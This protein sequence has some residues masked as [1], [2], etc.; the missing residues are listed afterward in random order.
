MPRG[1]VGPLC[2]TAVPGGRTRGAA[3]VGGL[4]WSARVRARGPPDRGLAWPPR[5]GPTLAAAVRAE[6]EGRG[7][8]ADADARGSGGRI[9]KAESEA[10]VY[11]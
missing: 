8:D 4:A 9:G 11:I 3:L 7:A 2:R 1:A 5:W 6:G 10:G